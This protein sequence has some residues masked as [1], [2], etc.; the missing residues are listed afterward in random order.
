MCKWIMKMMSIIDN[1]IYK[2][3]QD[4][5]ILFGSEDMCIDDQMVDDNFDS[6]DKLYIYILT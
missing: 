1:H 5:N 2:S 3:N 4:K 6:L